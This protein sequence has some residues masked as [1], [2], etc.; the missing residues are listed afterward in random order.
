MAKKFVPPAQ[1]TSPRRHWTLVA[2]VLDGG[3]GNWAAAIGR[4]DGKPVL[5]IRWNGNDDNPIGNPQSRGLPTWFVVPDELRGSILETI[6]RASPEKRP[7][8]DH[9]FA[10]Q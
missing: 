2:V 6:L 4:W 7:L 1:V 9:V 3:E 5:V 8:V 10:D